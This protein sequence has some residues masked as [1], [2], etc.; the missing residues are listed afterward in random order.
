M[1]T[2]RRKENSSTRKCEDVKNRKNSS[3]NF[4]AIMD[5]GNSKNRI[6]A[7]SKSCSSTE[8]FVKAEAEQEQEQEQEIEEEEG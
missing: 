7:N 8:S 6:K 2:D 1:S 4:A 3:K 5:S